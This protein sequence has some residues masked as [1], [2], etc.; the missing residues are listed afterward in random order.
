MKRYWSP[1]ESH[2]R[3]LLRLRG[4]GKAAWRDFFSNAKD[5]GHVDSRRRCATRESLAEA[6]KKPD[7]SICRRQAPGFRICVGPRGTG[8]QPAGLEGAVRYS[9]RHHHLLWRP[10]QKDRPSR[11]RPGGGRRQWRQ[12]HRVRIVPC[13]RVIGSDGSLDGVWRGDWL[14]K[15]KPWSMKR[16]ST[17]GTLRSF[18]LIRTSAG[19]RLPIGGR[20][21]RKKKARHPAKSAGRGRADCAA[22]ANDAAYSAGLSW[23]DCGLH[24]GRRSGNWGF[25]AQRLASRF[26]RVYRGCSLLRCSPISRKPIFT[27]LHWILRKPLKPHPPRHPLR[28]RPVHATKRRPESRR[29]SFLARPP[30]LPASMSCRRR[31]FGS[32][33]PSVG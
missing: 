14:L 20:D 22:I 31:C 28:A 7:R 5:A 29:L 26:C 9:V 2:L 4:R 3:N 10:G 23:S 11:F 21:Y 32:I 16:V 13:H 18:V 19:C 12:S 25:G 8:F 6:F 24:D 15:R 33:C 30:P 17:G 1:I 27:A